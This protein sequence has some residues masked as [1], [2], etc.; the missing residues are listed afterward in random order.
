MEVFVVNKHVVFDE[1]DEEESGGSTSAFTP[2]IEGGVLVGPSPDILESLRQKGKKDF[3][4]KFAKHSV[5]E[6]SV[7]SRILEGITVSPSTLL[8]YNR[9]GNLLLQRWKRE[10]RIMDDE[11]SF[12][13]VSFAIWLLGV[14]PTVKSS[15]WRVYRQAAIH[16]I[17]GIPDSNVEKALNILETDSIEPEVKSKSKEEDDDDKEDSSTKEKKF[18]YD[19]F[20]NVMRW[21][22]YDSRSK[23]SNHLIDWMIAAIFTGLRPIEWR[24][25]EVKTFEDPSNPK[26]R[27][28]WLYVL[29]AKSTNGRTTGIVRTLDLSEM[30]EKRIVVIKRHSDRCRSWFLNGEFHLRKGRIVQLLSR[31]VNN[32]TKKQYTLYSCRHQ[33]IANFKATLTMEETAAIVG[34]G[35]TKTQ[36]QHYGKRRS[37]WGPELVGKTPKGV[38]DEI[39]VVKQTLVTYAERMAKGKS[40]IDKY[41]E[42]FPI[43]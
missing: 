16:F 8:E 41:I 5:G 36:A 25:T 38:T 29:S 6:G 22:R 9:R 27:K 21:L 26:K 17:E 13:T 20:E 1:D 31:A 35:V 37:A 34:H 18:P 19:D 10:M 43:E 3:S 14:K 2:M 32:V 30:D 24:A 33:A 4:E 12:D 39:N 11:E 40:N 28:V 7:P 42:N 23:S 15:T